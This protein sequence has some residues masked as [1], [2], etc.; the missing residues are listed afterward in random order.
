MVAMWYAFSAWQCGHDL[1]MVVWWLCANCVIS[2]LCEMAP[3]C[4]GVTHMARSLLVVTCMVPHPTHS[5]V[6]CVLTPVVFS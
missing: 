2:W 6:V 1:L 5:S 3:R 4:V